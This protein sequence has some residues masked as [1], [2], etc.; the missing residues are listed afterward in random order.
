MIRPHLD[1]IDLIIDSGSV[2]RLSQLDKLQNKAIRRIEYCINS[3]KRKGMDVSYNIEKLTTRR[4]R[5]LLKI[6][7]KESKDNTNIEYRRPQ[8]ELR[9]KG[10]VKMKNDFTALTKVYMSPL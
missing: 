10:K 2:N 9:S 8:M 6:I 1:Y 4:K 3:D 5:N 7:Y